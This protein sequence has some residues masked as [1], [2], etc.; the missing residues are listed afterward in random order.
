MAQSSPKIIYGGGSL[1]TASVEETRNVLKVLEELDINTID[2]AE[3]YGKSEEN[4]GQAYAASRFTID[5]KVSVAMGGSELMTKDVVLNHA[6]ES[7]R[8]LNTDT[9][10]FPSSKSTV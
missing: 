10:S 1:W 5:T 7:L 6:R 2:T 4:L 8:R 3:S 9:V